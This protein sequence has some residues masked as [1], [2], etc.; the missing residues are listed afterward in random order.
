MVGFGG[1]GQWFAVS[2]RGI[3]PDLITFAKG[4][5][6]GYVPLGGVVIS[7]EIR[8]FYAHRSF[9]AGL[10]FSGHPLACAVAVESMKTFVDED[11]LERNRDL[12][13]RVVRSRLKALKEK[14]AVVGDV[15]GLG[16]FR[17]IELVRD[18]QIR[19]PLVPFNAAGAGN[20]PMTE[21]TTLCQAEGVWLWTHFNGVHIGPPLVIS[22]E[23]LIRGLEVTDRML[24]D[25]DRYAEAERAGR[26]TDLVHLFQVHRRNQLIAPVADPERTGPPVFRPVGE[27]VPVRDH[28]HLPRC[29]SVERVGR[30]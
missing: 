19:E 9:R 16:L 14:H 8:D 27:A 28:P 29:L 3:G 17:V 23:D 12:G 26:S 21:F 24:G 11:I 7:D 25:L 2:N 22:E 6:S 5:N 4:V 30:Q 20:G 1:T 13:G 18:A 15:R 10:T